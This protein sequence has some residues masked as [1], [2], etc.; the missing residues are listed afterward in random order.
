MIV[1]QF[2]FYELSPKCIELCCWRIFVD[3]GLFLC[4]FLTL[5]FASL[6]KRCFL[7]C[8]EKIIWLS[9]LLLICKGYLSSRR[10]LCTFL[11]SSCRK[12]TRIQ[13]TSDLIH[14]NHSASDCL[15]H[16]PRHILSIPQ[17]H[18]ILE[19][20]FVCHQRNLYL[21][22]LFKRFFHKWIRRKRGLPRRIVRE[23]LRLW[24]IILI[25][26]PDLYRRYAWMTTV[27]LLYFSF[28]LFI[29]LS[30]IIFVFTT[31][32][33]NTGLSILLAIITLSFGVV[34]IL[35]FHDCQFTYKWPLA[36]VELH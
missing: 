13:Q 16:C 2:S 28:I 31:P 11:C 20:L 6:G 30:L 26:C 9:W 36:L 1:L 12:K 17:L 5:S 23:N 8:F 27:W 29:D 35:S 24:M 14:W 19:L 3:L 33:T 34:V 10:R 7:W 4:A 18:N 25:D 22:Q 32:K 15:R 21:C